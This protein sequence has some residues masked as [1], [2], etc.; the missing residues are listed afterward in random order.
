M[1]HLEDSAS[2]RKSFKMWLLPFSNASSL[3][4]I[5]PVY[6]F[7]IKIMAEFGATVTR[8][9]SALRCFSSDQI[10]DCNLWSLAVYQI[11][12]MHLPSL[13]VINQVLVSRAQQKLSREDNFFFRS[14]FSR[15]REKYFGAFVDAEPRYPLLT[16]DIKL[17]TFI[18]NWFMSWKICDCRGILL[19]CFLIK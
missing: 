8:C 13:N 2:T 18:N 5:L 3:P 1:C 17:T 9:F 6:T 19:L 11:I 12:L 7:E 10:T 14:C 4:L 16:R 15:A